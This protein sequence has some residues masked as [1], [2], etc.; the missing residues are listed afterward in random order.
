MAEHSRF[1]KATGMEIYFC[2]PS[3]VERGSNES[4]YG[5]LRRYVPRTLDF[6]TLTQADF[7]AIAGPLN[8]RPRQTLVSP[9]QRT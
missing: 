6:G 8:G 7:D 3:R 1:T 5:L 9:V 4:T 2:D